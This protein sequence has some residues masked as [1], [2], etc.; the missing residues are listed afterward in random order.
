MKERGAKAKCAKK[1]RT[2]LNMFSE[3]IK[4]E[5]IFKKRFYPLVN[6]TGLQT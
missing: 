2:V 5:S 4:Q 1:V 3:I 6:F